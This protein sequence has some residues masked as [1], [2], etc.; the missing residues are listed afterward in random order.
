M[1][2][3]LLFIPEIPM[4]S[5]VLPRTL[6]AALVIAASTVLSGCGWFRSEPVYLDSREARPLEVP[7]DLVLPSS[8]AALQ[9]PPAPAGATA[10][11]EAPPP[12]AGPATS[13]E[14]TDSA[15]SAF[16]RVGLALGRIEGVTATPVAALGSHEVS[17]KGESFLVRIAA[18]GEIVRIDAI[19]PTGTA[20]S[21][22]VAGELL[23][24]LQ[25]RLR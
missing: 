1:R 19:S 23:G 5:S 4:R 15:E 3:P 12:A 24:L 9:I 22:G 20:I 14:I 25:A 10:P 8:A 16:R 21:G 6:P 11:G 18:Q 7:P 2:H 13:F 17:F